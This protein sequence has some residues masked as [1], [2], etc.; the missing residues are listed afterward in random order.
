MCVEADAG[1]VPHYM[2][3]MDHAY[4]RHR[5][6][7]AP[8]ISLSKLP[9][10]YFAEHIYVTFQDDWTAFRQAD[11]MNWRRLMWANDFPHS[12]SDLAVVAGDARRTGRPA[13]PRAAPGDPVAATSPTCTTST[14]PKL[15]VTQPA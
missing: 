2:Y 13:Q 1:W 3:R 11:D 7:L 8:G 4:K 15:P 10:E 14:S 12:D 5:N 9:S 6:W